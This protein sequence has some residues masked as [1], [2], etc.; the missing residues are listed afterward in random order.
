MMMRKRIAVIGAGPI[1]LEAALLARQRGFEVTVLERGQV[2]SHVRKWQHVTLFSPFE[3]NTSQW[4]RDAVA[5]AGG[6]LPDFGAFLSG[7]TFC[8]RYLIPL[9][10][11][12]LLR[13]SI[14][15]DVEVVTVSRNSLWK[16]D[17]I[18]RP[19]RLESP[20]RLLLQSANENSES[21]LEADFVFDCSGVF[22]SH[23]WLGPGGSP[24]LGE[25]AL[26]SRIDYQLPDV[27]G[28]DRDRFEGRRVLVIGSGYSAATAIVELSQLQAESTNA[29][30][31]WLT[32]RERE[33]PLP[34]IPDDPLPERGRLTQL[35][36]E[37]ATAAEQGRGV[38]W[39][40]SAVVRELSVNEGAD[41]RV[42]IECH[43]NNQL[44]SHSLIVDSVV[45]LVG[46]KPDR[47]VYEE[48]Q[49]HECYASQGPMRLAA[50]LAE[51]ASA[52]CLTQQG[53][54]ADTL[55][56][57]EPGFFIL[58][59]KSYGRDSRFLLRIGHKQIESAMSLID[60]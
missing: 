50:S 8:E 7:E 36:N 56:N 41:I 43:H 11:H 52:D 53:G 47:S 6:T 48:L 18:G 32:R 16:G 2:A 42:E 28:Q 24:A 59:A 31:Y 54:K 55:R 60:S 35:A 21:V 34:T 12:D 30:T 10:Q 29:V 39:I 9:S 22:G 58:G 25:R 40:P 44:R 38:E 26:E 57:P 19:D 3:M 33:V 51:Q 27:L 17:Q 14:R 45:A 46:Y 20:F 15:E 23:N 1:G 13:D 4:G 49:I 37:L 5:E